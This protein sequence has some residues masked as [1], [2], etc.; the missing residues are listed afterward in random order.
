M[1]QVIKPSGNPGKLSLKFS[2]YTYVRTVIMRSVLFRRDDYNKMLKMGFGEIAK[3]LEESHYKKEIDELA[4]E[5]SGADLLELALN[6]NLAGSFKK[7]IRISSNEMGML[8]REYIKRKDIEDI[9]TVIRGKFTNTGDK[10]IKSSLTAAGTLSYD[11]LLSLLKKDSIEDILKSSRIVDY[12]S[13]K[14]AVQILNEKKSLAGIENALDRRYYSDLMGFSKRLSKKGDMFRKFLI[15]ETEVLNILTI[16]RLKKA[17]FKKELVKEFLIPS[18]D[19]IKDSK[20]ANMANLNNASDVLTLL[21]NSEY[22]NVISN[23]AQEFSKSNS[24]IT[25][26]IELYKYLLRQSLLFTHQYPLSIESIIGYMFAK[27]IEVRN[28]KL[29]VK[30]RQLGLKDQFIES[31]LIY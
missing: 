30:G 29:I 6:R 21:E 20:I 17:G 4:A 27:D 11:F 15:K 19:L 3:F 24:L 31:Q 23:G 12:S 5:H 10:K 13:L 2:P 7:L 9:K 22:R 14:G 25:L 8:V 26:E 16:L 18:G 28:L 1:L